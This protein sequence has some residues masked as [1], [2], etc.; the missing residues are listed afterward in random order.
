MR[1]Q[2]IE[3]TEFVYNEEEGKVLA[4][5]LKQTTIQPA[6]EAVLMAKA[7][8]RDIIIEAVKEDIANKENEELIALI[9]AME[10]E[11]EWLTEVEK[12]KEEGRYY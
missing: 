2:V 10:N 6:S 5:K 1:E 3:E 8:T 4:S 12:A 7:V 9:E 11:N